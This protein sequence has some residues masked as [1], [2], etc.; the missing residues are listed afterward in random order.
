[1]QLSIVATLYRSAPYLR[2]FHARATAAARRVTESYEIVLVNDGSPDPS[3]EIALELHAAD[4][5]VRVV[6]LSRNF[7]HH[8]A[9]WIGLQQ[10]RGAQVFLIDTD[11]EESPE[12]LEQLDQT[13]TATGADVVYGVQ[14]SR[15]G[16]WAAHW[17]AWAFYKLFNALSDQPIPENLMTVR[18]M[19]RRYLDALLQHREVSFTI[20]GLWARTGFQQVPLPL[21]KRHKRGTSYSLLRRA[22]L[23]VNAITAF[24]NKP[25]L[26]VFSLG[27]FILVVSGLIATGLVIDR[28]LGG[29]MLSGW[30]S[31]MV[32]LWFLGG[33]II[34]CQGIQGIYL[35]N[36]YLEA[37]RRPIALVR[38]VYEQATPAQEAQRLA[39]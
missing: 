6:D 31:L 37:K 13:R 26:L 7:G 17:G 23:C 32:S 10:A 9:I 4:P 39:G 11:L 8:Q 3:L 1:M 25:L 36:V 15:H 18:L 12:W 20:S 22:R 28:L 27:T 21:P 2:E 38:R 5:H 29:T 24:S 33:L 34:F 30:P 14:Q 16:A 35:A 19:S